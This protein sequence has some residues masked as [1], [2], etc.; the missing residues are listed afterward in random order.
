MKSF[1]HQ[2]QLDAMDC[3]PACLHMIV[4]YYGRS[5]P[6]SWIRTQCGIGKDGVSLLGL[7]EAAE[8]MGMQTLSAKI[9]IEQLANEIVLPC[10]LH[11][12]CKH[13]VVC[14]EVTG[15]KGKRKIKISDP[16]LG[17]V[18]YTEKELFRHW[19]SGCFE[20][21]PTGLAMQIEPNSQFYSS[22]KWARD[23]NIPSLG[24]NSFL[25]YL[26]PHKQSIFQLLLGSVAMMLLAYASPLITQ[27]VVDI[28]I[29]GKNLRF[30][31]LMMIMQVIIAI[32]NT[33]IVFVQSW[34][35][36]HMNTLININLIAD[37]LKKLSQMPISFL[38]LAPW[39]TFFNE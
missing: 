27:A 15:K 1:P 25:R 14:Y 34:I 37:Y 39:E 24:L 21:E 35:S 19:I 5:Y 4:Q 17:K 30:I 28:G 31:L 18:T 6:I 13:F 8:S 20:G 32:S 29:L 2:F 36:L 9:T 7:S 26:I 22:P 16:A 23:M 11:W 12:D 38:K 3:G 33:S 10:I